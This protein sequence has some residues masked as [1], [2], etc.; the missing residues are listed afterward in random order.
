MS[1]SNTKSQL[2]GTNLLIFWAISLSIVGDENF[3][4]T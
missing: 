3:V 4:V 1:M 2:L